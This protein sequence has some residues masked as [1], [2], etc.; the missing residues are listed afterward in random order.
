M[1]GGE[2]TTWE[3]KIR[4]K[5]PVSGGSKFIFGNNE[6]KPSVYCLQGE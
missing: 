4:K 1:D 5:N 6:F 2:S 3:R